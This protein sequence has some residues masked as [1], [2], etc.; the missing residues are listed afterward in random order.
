MKGT[1]PTNFHNILFLKM[2]PCLVNV[3]E[4]QKLIGASWG[5]LA[6]K[7]IIEK[8]CYCVFAHFVVFRPCYSVDG[9]GFAL[10]YL[11]PTRHGTV[12]AWGSS[13]EDKSY[14]TN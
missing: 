11:G 8:L 6:A 14:S 13:S 1:F 4:I 7:A 9:A 10:N 5:K 2:K 12:Q 3:S